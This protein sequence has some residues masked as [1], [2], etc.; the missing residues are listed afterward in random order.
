[1][2][3][4]KKR[5]GISF[6]GPLTVDI[7]HRGREE[8]PSYYRIAQDRA[9]NARDHLPGGLGTWPDH[10]SFSEPPRRKWLNWFE[11]L[12]LYLDQLLLVLL[13]RGFEKKIPED[14]HRW[15]NSHLADRELYELFARLGEEGEPEFGLNTDDL[16][17]LNEVGT[18]MGDLFKIRSEPRHYN[19]RFGSNRTLNIPKSDRF[20]KSLDLACYVLDRVLPK[21]RELWP[22]SCL[23]IEEGD[24]GV[25]GGAKVSAGA[26]E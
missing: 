13:Y 4:R 19:L 20:K 9:L 21:Y 22:E 24:S 10:S 5:N 18:M 15:A 14:T 11:D 12:R 17:A 25:L 2:F 23:E 1:M 16:R 3:L 26:L 8:I 7:A 6:K